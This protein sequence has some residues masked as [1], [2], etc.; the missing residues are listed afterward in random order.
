MTN[1]ITTNAFT[2]AHCAS[3]FV[4][5]IS[6]PFQ[7]ALCSY[8]LYQQIGIATFIG[9]ATMLVF[10]PLNAYLAGLGK[11]LRREKYKLQ[12]TR[13]KTMN[14]VL[15]GIRMIRFYGW[16]L[17]FQGLVKGVRQTELSK[18]VRSALLSTVTAL[19]WACV[20]FVVACVAFAVYLLMDEKNNLD[21]NRAFVSLTLFNML[22]VPLNQLPHIIQ[23]L[24]QV[25]ERW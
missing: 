1:L 16:E 24:I 18:L 13:I 10:I 15:A 14:E 12:D 3:N 7:I 6:S 20:P 23:G 11:R 4:G 2:F 19:T 25:T 5:I 22:R 8:L 17:S 9:M 21:P